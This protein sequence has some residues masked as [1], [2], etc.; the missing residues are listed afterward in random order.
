MGTST[1][2]K[3][4]HPFFASPPQNVDAGLVFALVSVCDLTNVF[5]KLVVE[6]GMPEYF[7]QV[8]L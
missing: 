5:T 7:Y 4:K 6:A 8:K 1:N 3:Y 2:E